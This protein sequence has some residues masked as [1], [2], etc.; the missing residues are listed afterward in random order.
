MVQ[1]E[2]KFE[3]DGLT[4]GTTRTFTAPDKDGTLAMTSDITT[5]SIPYTQD[6]RL[7]LTTALPVTTSD[8]TGATTIYAVPKTGNKISL[9]NGSTWDVITS[10]QFSLALGTLTS[11]KPYDVF[12]YNNSG[13]ATLE[14]TAW[15]NDSTR[16]TALA[17]QD[18]VLVK[19]GTATRRYL[20][21]FYT[22]ATTT[23]EDSLANRYLYNYYHRA[24]RAMYVT[25]GTSSWTYTTAALRQANGN[26][27]NQLNFFQG[28]AEDEVSFMA[29]H[30]VGNSTSAR[31]ITAIGLDSTSAQHANC[32]VGQTVGNSSGLPMPIKS[33]LNIIPAAGRHYASWLEYSEASGTSTWYSANIGSFKV[34]AI[35][36][37]IM[38]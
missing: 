12:C 36:G 29:S 20:G 30:S 23:T 25:D 10:A 27:A 16:A 18:G 5:P 4:T 6:F 9:Y 7:S 28:V 22:T 15:T 35:T 24:K 37:E 11:G 14:F 31:M 17:Y 1:N 2:I 38:A 19:S 21:T 34:G 32:I 13:T 33:T 3:V 8:V 26:T